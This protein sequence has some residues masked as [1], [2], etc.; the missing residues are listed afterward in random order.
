MKDPIGHAIK[1]CFENRI[2][3][4]ISI[5]TNY[6]EDE[7]IPPS[8]FFR[9]YNDMPAVERAA[10]DWSTG[11]ILDVGAGAGSHSLYLQQKGF[12]VTALEKS[13]PAT[14]VIKRRGVKKFVH[15][16]LYNFDETEFDT[17]LV[18]M[19]GTGIGGTLPGLKKLLLHLKS[20][21]AVNGQILIDSTD[22][23]YLFEEEDGSY[24]VDLNSNRYFG[25]MDYEVSYNNEKTTFKWLFT[26]FDTLKKISSEAGLKCR[27]VKSGNNHDYLARLTKD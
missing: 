1:E 2:V 26:D 20:L 7:S 18:L 12:D 24:W 11:K 9:T 13:K 16:D 6:T 10:L 22:I 27:K 8:W 21:L 5:N 25:E 4:D 14:E 23:R 19:N 17:I 3:P 15:S